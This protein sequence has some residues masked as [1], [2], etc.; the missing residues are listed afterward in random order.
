MH[1]KVNLFQDN[2]VLYIITTI[3]NNRAKIIDKN[4]EFTLKSL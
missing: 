1:K 4:Y 2:T 3:L